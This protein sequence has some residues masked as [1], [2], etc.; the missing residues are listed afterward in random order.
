MVTK[1][2]SATFTGINGTIINVEIDISNGLPAFNIVGIPDIAVKESKERVRAAIIN[3]GFEF[4]MRRITINLA[5]ADLKKEGSLLDLPIAIAILLA[6][7]QI[8]CDNIE[9]FLFIGE[10]SLLGELKKIR[11]SLPIIIDAIENGLSNF[12]V[13]MDN[14]NECAFVNDAKVFPFETLSQVIEF[15]KYRDLIPYKFEE[16]KKILKDNLDF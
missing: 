12:I 16:N 10:L 4:P 5:P 2:K 1:I 3:S 13:P 11:G 6:S 9:E 7:D 15:L 14:A 8:K